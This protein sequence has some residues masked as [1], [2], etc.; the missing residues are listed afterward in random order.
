L[1][2][3][4]YVVERTLLF[5]KPD[6]AGTPREGEAKRDLQSRLAGLGCKIT[7]SWNGNPEKRFFE[8]HYAEHA[9]KPFY[10]ELLAFVLAGPVTLFEVEGI[11][12]VAKCRAMVGPTDSNK[13]RVEAPES[14]RAKWGT[15]LQRNGIHASADG[16]AAKRELSVWRR[17][18]EAKR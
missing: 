10:G 1:G 9:Q 8:A 3:W 7:A 17:Y 13:A 4:F 18:L 12:C 15:D 2:D 6:L 16:E 14:F 11:G 5:F